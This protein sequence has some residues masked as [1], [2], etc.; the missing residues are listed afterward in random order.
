MRQIA[1]NLLV[2]AVW[3]LLTAGLVRGIYE[4]TE[5]TT[6]GAGTAFALWMVGQFVLLS[7]LVWGAW[8]ARN[9][10]AR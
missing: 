4:I 8:R 7:P 6:L 5:R 1:I 10:G 3:L 9:V 2:F